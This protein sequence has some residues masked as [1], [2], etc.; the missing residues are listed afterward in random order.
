MATQ[1]KLPAIALGTWSWGIGDAGGDQIFGHHLDESDLRPVV[2]AA[3]QG[4]LTLWDTAYAYGAGDSERILGDLLNDYARET[5]TL[6]TKFTPQLATDD[7]AVTEMLAGSLKR[8]KTDYIDIYWIHNSDDVARWTPKLIPLLQSGQIRQ[9]GVSNHNLSQI[10]QANQILGTAGF[11]VSA[12]QNHFSLLDRASEQEG[13]LDYCRENDIKF[14]AYMVLEQG[15]LTGKYDMVHPLPAD[16][17]RG[18]VYNPM[19][20]ELTKLVQRMQA[21]G[22]T[23]D[24]TV[25]EVATAWALAKGTL[26]ILG[27]TKPAYVESAKRALAVKLSANEIR[28]LEALADATHLDTRGGW[29]HSI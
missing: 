17:S 25:A 15:A 13:I 2:D 12:V 29:E 24:A 23:Q 3:M 22:T 10:K 7:Q 11:K 14:F 5:Y 9:V 21:I 27:V 1:P 8:L 19:L 28:D 18:N 20:P 26:P 6:S 4:G 16:S